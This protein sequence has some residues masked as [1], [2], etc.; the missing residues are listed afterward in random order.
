[1]N[2]LESKTITLQ[3]KG[4]D[5]FIDFLKGICILFVVLNHCL[6]SKWMDNSLFC[7]WGSTAVPLFLILQVFHA[8][9]GGTNRSS[10]NGAKVWHRVVR[11]FL[12]VEL[13]IISYHLITQT[14]LGET[15]L[16][17]FTKTA[18][19]WGGIG[20]G[21]YYPWIYVQFAVVMPVSAIVFRHVKGTRLLILFIIISTIIDILGTFL[22]PM[23]LYRL[24]FL[25]YVF[26]FYLGYIL[27][28]DGYRINAKTLTMALVSMAATLL[29]FYNEYDAHPFIICTWICYVYIAFG[30]FPFLKWIYRYTYICPPIEKG[31]RWIGIHSYEV[32]LIQMLVFSIINIYQ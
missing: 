27:A 14:V 21:C 17:Q 2:L 19:L 24:L 3:H 7:I 26:L 30:F 6:P 8:F 20:P 22:V 28:N 11:P 31:L 16:A 29:L 15:S 32:F 12:L 10:F 1:M 4:H 13:V 25:R 9:K 5:S 18:L 23:R